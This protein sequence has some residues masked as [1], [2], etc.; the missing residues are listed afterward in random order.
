MDQL[1]QKNSERPNVEGVI[2]SFVLDHFGS[3]VLE[4]ATESVSLLV[5]VG[6]YTPSKVT[7][8]DNI[9]LLYQYI[10]RFDISVNQSLLVHVVDA[11]A[12]L[13]EEVEGGVLA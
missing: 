5:C 10:L 8:F 7:Y 3:H 6:L 13:N 9:A 2:V 11:G 4:C 1:V 12:H